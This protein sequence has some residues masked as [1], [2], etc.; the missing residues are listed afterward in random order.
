MWWICWRRMKNFRRCRRNASGSCKLFRAASQLGMKVLSYSPSVASPLRPSP[1]LDTEMADG[2]S[3]LTGTPWDSAQYIVLLPRV[4]SCQPRCQRR[5]LS[6]AVPHLVRRTQTN[7]QKGR[8]QTERLSQAFLQWRPLVMKR[9]Q[10]ALPT[11]R[12]PSPAAVLACI[13]SWRTW[14]QSPISFKLGCWYLFRT[15]SGYPNSL[16]VMTLQRSLVL[17]VKFSDQQ[18]RTIVAQWSAARPWVP[19][20]WI[21][22]ISI[23]GA[24]YPLQCL[25]LNSVSPERTTSS[26]G[27][28]SRSMWDQSM[29]PRSGCLL[30]SS[31]MFMY[32]NATEL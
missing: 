30:M 2:A 9:A 6:L 27:R 29:V 25:G 23:P 24:E 22:L 4:Y 11:W 21:Q 32:I 3:T 26:T 16:M 19:P 5:S 13:S 1:S 15:M 14:S 17:L 12:S 31:F 10:S 7:Y 28:V 20:T 18:R 8:R